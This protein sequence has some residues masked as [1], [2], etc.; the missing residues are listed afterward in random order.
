VILS[1]CHLIPPSSKHS[2]QHPVLEHCFP[3]PWK[4]KFYTHTK[5]Q[6]KSSAYLICTCYWYKTGRWRIL[7]WL[8]ALHK[9]NYLPL[10]LLRMQL[11]FYVVLHYSKSDM[12]SNTASLPPGDVL[13]YSWQLRCRNTVLL[14]MTLLDM[15]QSITLNA[16][17]LVSSKL[18]FPIVGLNTSPV[19]QFALI[20]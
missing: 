3:S 11:I 5:R 2:P 8:H 15:A 14:A 4:T 13:V 9:L 17:S 19:P 6:S 1:T 10:N 18:T 16:V 12:Q 7:E 20:F